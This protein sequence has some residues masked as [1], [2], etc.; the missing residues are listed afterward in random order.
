M[1]PAHVGLC[2]LHALLGLA[3]GGEFVAHADD[4]GGLA[5]AA[6]LEL[7]DEL[8]VSLGSRLGGLVLLVGGP[9]QQGEGAEQGQAVEG[10][11]QGGHT[12]TLTCPPQP[13][14]ACRW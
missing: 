4:A 7:V 13:Q 3:L 8:G 5:G 1:L 6:L 10:L 12:A 11:A 2:R 9:E 14:S